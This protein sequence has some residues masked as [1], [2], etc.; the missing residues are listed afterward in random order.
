MAPPLPLSLLRAF[1]AAARTG[2]FRAAAEELSLTPSAVSHAVRKLEDQLGVVLFVRSTRAVRLS[3]DGAALIGHVG[4][5]FE[6][7]RRGIDLISTSGPGLLRLHCAPSFAATWL[8]PRLSRFLNANPEIDVRLAANTDYARFET[9][10]F[11]AD[12][13]YGEVK[14]RDGIVV[15][16][17]GEETVVPLC[18]PA[19]AP[20]IRKPAD[21]LHQTL[22][23][24]DNK[25]IRW[26]H[27]FEANGLAPPPA[28]GARFDRSFLAIA[29]AADGLGVALESTRLAE[30]EIRSGLLVRP[31][32]G[33]ARDITYVGHHLV[34]PRL[35]S[36][37]QTIRALVRWLVA[38][39]GLD[40]AFIDT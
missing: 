30:R 38:E 28:Q 8:T 13:I 18:T 16:P 2:S 6:E 3:P 10:E 17:L 25:L 32:A 4:R 27:W 1:E 21:L 9:N 31:L 39:L 29:A 23:Q 20:Y 37:R 7:I 24:S 26:P 5:G 34:F 19:L 33:R 11:D 15:I 36:R 14:P 35:A 40:P 12:I 22:L